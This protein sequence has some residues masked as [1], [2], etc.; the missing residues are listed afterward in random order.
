MLHVTENTLTRLVNYEKTISD[1]KQY[2]KCDMTSVNS[3][4]TLEYLNIQ[5]ILRSENLKEYYLCN[6]FVFLYPER[7][8]TSTK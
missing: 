3:E 4:K 5:E 1:K 7:Y 8:Y 2:D 6:T